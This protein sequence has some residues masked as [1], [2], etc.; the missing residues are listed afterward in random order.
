VRTTSGLTRIIFV[1]GGI[2]SLM[3][4]SKNE[5]NEKRVRKAQT[6]A[7]ENQKSRCERAFGVAAAL[8]N[9]QGHPP[10]LREQHLEG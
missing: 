6:A 8:G 1:D 10:L 2:L 4:K 9:P 5:Q 3:S 7:A